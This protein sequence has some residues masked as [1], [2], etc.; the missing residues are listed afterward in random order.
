MNDTVSRACVTCMI[1]KNKRKKNQ[2]QRGVTR[3]KIEELIFDT[4]GEW[5]SD[6][7]I[8]RALGISRQAVNYHTRAMDLPRP[9]RRL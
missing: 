2:Q 3:R 5:I 1:R 4:W 7:E 8:A 9:K 6:A